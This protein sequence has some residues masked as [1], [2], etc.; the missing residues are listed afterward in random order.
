L[1]SRSI[2]YSLAA[3]FLWS[4][5][6]TA[7]KLTLEG[8]NFIQL[9]FYSSVA[10]FFSIVLIL[11]FKRSSNYFSFI[12]PKYFFRNLLLGILN[13]FLYYL[14]L[15]SAYSLLPA[16]EAQP[17]NYTWPIVLSVFSVIFLKNK[18]SLKTIIGLIISFFGVWV[19]A[20][21]GDIIGL[22]FHDIWGVILA[23]GSSVI[24]ASYWIISMKDQRNAEEKLLAAFFYGTVITAVYISFYDSFLISK[25]V[26]LFGA[27]YIGFFEMG[28]TFFLWMKGLEM[29]E[30]K[31]KTSTLAYMA[32]FLSIVFIHF[33]LGEK[34]FLSSIIGLIFIIGGIFFQR[35][36]S[37]L[38]LLKRNKIN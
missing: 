10:S 20:T 5:V 11:V 30:D 3:V 19:I 27:A 23:T 29:S 18:F 32:P 12:S 24:W 25:P 35:S 36:E 28:I 17:L 4:T 2:L 16:Q 1:N 8:M 38:N 37:I 15:F 6:A 31:S 7:F 22:T 34:L 9:L 21:R 14:V 33:I 13:P 26:F